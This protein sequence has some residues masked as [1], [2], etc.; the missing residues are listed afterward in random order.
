MTKPGRAGQF[1]AC[2]I[3]SDLETADPVNAR[4]VDVEYVISIVI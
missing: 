4:W 3:V 1:F 2:D